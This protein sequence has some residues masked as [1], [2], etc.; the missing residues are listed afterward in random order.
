M[1]LYG[2][3]TF[4][5]T[6]RH[7]DPTQRTLGA[8]NA[9]LFRSCCKVFGVHNVTRIDEY[10]TTANCATC[11]T[12][13]DS[14]SR[15]PNEKEKA[16]GRHA[17]ISI[18]GLKHCPKCHKFLSRDC[19]AALNIADCVGQRPSCLQQETKTHTA[20][21]RRAATQAI[22]PDRASGCSR[23]TSLASSTSVQ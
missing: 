18:R 13:L 21:T 23:S 7:K 10:H 9:K 4:S 12:R 20:R 16:R 22:L 3:A 15:P 19:N 17:W 14:R 8:P 6:F 2:G 5:S 11:G 1:M